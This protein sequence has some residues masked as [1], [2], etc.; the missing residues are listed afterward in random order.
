MALINCSECGK[1]ISDKAISC[2]NCGCPVSELISS[3]EKQSTGDKKNSKNKKVA[4]ICGIL[5][6]LVLVLG[7]SVFGPNRQ[8]TKK[9]EETL[10]DIIVGEWDFCHDS[11][12]TLKMK[13][14]T[15][16]TGRLAMYDENGEY[17]GGKDFKYEIDEN[18]EKLNIS[19]FSGFTLSNITNKSMDYVYDFGK[20]GKA[21]KK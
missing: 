1:K 4:I 5:V 6:V 18:E 17:Q 12:W 16:G 3:E 8:M 14:Y 13:F 2:P 20:E 19:N 10:S 11:G 7:A 15:D 9:S 21:Y